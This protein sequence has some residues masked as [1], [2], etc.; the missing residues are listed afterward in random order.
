MPGRFRSIGKWRTADLA[1]LRDATVA[2]GEEAEINSSAYLRIF[3]MKLRTCRVRQLWEHLADVLVVRGMLSSGAENIIEHYLSH[4]TLASRILAALPKKFGRAEL[5][6]VY[7]RLADCL[8]EG[9]LFEPR[10]Q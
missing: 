4:G 10:R 9:T 1:R 8:A 2:E 5:T 7:R 6:D 3:G